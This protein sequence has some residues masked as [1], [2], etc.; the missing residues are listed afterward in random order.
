MQ[1]I[2]LDYAAST[3]IDPDVAEKMYQAL[4]DT[5]GNPASDTHLFGYKAKQLVEQARKQV[6][7]AINAEPNEIV[8]TSGA[9]EADNLAL[10]GVAEFHGHKGKHIITV[11]TEHKAILDTCKVLEKQGFSVTYLPVEKNGLIS[12]LELQAAITSETILISVMLVNNETGVIQDVGAIAEIAHKNNIFLHVDGAQAIGKIKLDVKAMDIDLLSLSAHKAYG[13]KGVGA[14]YVRRKP[15]VKIA[16]QMH[17]GCHEFGMRSGT[18]ATHQSVGMGVAFAIATDRLSQNMRHAKQLQQL[19]LSGLTLID[20]IKIN[21]DPTH[22]VAN[23]INVSFGGVNGDALLTA[24]MP[25]AVSTGSACN[26]VSIEPSH[27]LQA[28]QVPLHLAASSIRFSFG[29]FTTEAQI[30]TALE[31]IQQGVMQLRKLA[32]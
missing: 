2:Y 8:W 28:M 12:L 1:A 23:I 21:S 7:S 29:R 19:F 4:T 26:S 31:I 30:K 6:A 20:D 11:K 14:L 10:K 22:S 3:P 13:P 25:L 24:L 9:T 32:P 15:R 27:V 5:F 17:G 16:A 18:L